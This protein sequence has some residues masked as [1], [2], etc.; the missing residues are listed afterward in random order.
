MRRL[1]LLLLVLMAVMN[2]HAADTLSVA[3]RSYER[4]IAW[5]HLWHRYTDPV[6]LHH[7]Q[8]RNSL[9]SFAAQYEGRT[10]T[11][12][13]YDERGRGE[14]IARLRAKTYLLP[15][16]REHL[17]GYADYANGRV[18]EVKWRSTSDYDRLYPY[19]MADA[20]GGDLSLE[21]YTFGG[22][23]SHQLSRLRLS[24]EMY[25]RSQQEYRA[26][27]PRPRSIVSDLRLS[28]G[29]SLPVAACEVGLSLGYG[30]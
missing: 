7:R 9:S 2:A 1:L 26:V 18:K 16:A 19:I 3:D 6:A 24:G 17:W 14:S 12:T 30:L 5:Q 13:L 15:S 28:T 8:Y 27:D 22:G 4:A 20:K 25:Y 21:R 23:Y 29:L 11:E 10:E